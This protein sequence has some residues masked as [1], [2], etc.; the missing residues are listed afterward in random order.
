MKAKERL[1]K[2]KKIQRMND[3]MKDKP[4]SRPS[5]D[6]LKDDNV[7]IDFEKLKVV[8]ERLRKQKDN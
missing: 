7:T 3:L 6:I 4:M 8:Q 5:S 2:A 1:L